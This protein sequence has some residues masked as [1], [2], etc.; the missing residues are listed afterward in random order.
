V[1]YQ[2]ITAIATIV[3]D[4]LLLAS[5]VL[6]CWYLL[7]TR[8]MRKAAERQVTETQALVKASDEQAEAQIRPAV[9]VQ[10][11]NP[12]ESLLLVNVGK[13]PAL[14]LIVSP[15]ERGAA[16]SRE[17]S[18]QEKYDVPVSF[19]AAGGDS[20]SGV[21]TQQH[22]GLLGAVLNGKSLQ[23]QCTSL[24]GRTYWTVVDF[25]HATGNTVENTRF[26]I[27]E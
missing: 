25:D 23:C 8:K 15:A 17:C 7:E 5:A 2:R 4:L 21:R 9:V 19:L 16:G 24:S 14:N 22:P 1:D 27:E 11:R 13:G 10:V 12:P 6:I 20:F 18:D 26:N 3:Q